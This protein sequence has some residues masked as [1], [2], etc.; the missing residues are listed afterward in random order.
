M[1]AVR[2]ARRGNVRRVR[3]PPRHARGRHAKPS[4][5][6][7]VKCRRLI[8]GVSTE[9]SRR[10]VAAVGAG[11]AAVVLL[12]LAV[13]AGFQVFS[14]PGPDVAARSGLPPVV[15]PAGRATT[16]PA[17]VAGD[18]DEVPAA[19]AYLRRR[20]P[21]SKIGRHVREVRRSGSYLRVYTDLPEGKENSEDA[22][23]LCEWTAEYLR[24]RGAPA[25]VVFVHA[26]RNGNG[27]VVLANKLGA[28]DGCEVGETR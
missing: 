4:S 23:S 16:A 8:H 27:N 3:T 7:T 12:G 11:A 2:K 25:P 21:G 1:Y 26:R 19:L 22:V 5:S 9:R 10:R 14:G 6:L 13:A 24:E 18:P 17:A 15:T 28:K 20:E